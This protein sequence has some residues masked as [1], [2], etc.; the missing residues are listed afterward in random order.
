MAGRN[1]ICSTNLNCPIVNEC[2]EVFL[3]YSETL[4]GYPGILDGIWEKVW[5][6][7]CLV[8]WGFFGLGVFFVFFFFFCVSETLPANSSKQ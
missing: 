4:F 1:C 3:L 8:F 5:C 2:D 7:G 6:F